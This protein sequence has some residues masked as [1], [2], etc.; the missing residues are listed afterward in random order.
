MVAPRNTPVEDLIRSQFQSE[1]E[2]TDQC[3]S[4]FKLLIAVNFNHCSKESAPSFDVPFGTLMTNL[5]LFHV[6]EKNLKHARR[7]LE[8]NYHLYIR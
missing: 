5:Q 8:I 7:I 4:N 1:S 6:V 3:S 2:F